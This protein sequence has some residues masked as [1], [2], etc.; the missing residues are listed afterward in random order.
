MILTIL[1]ANLVNLQRIHA[2]MNL[3]G[4]LVEHTRIHDTRLANALYLFWCLDQFT[5]RHQLTFVFPV[6]DGLVHFR[7]FLT[8]QTVPSLFLLKCVHFFLQVPFNTI[9]A[10]KLRKLFQI[11]LYL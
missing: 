5:S 2:R 6:H 9:R 8:R 11:V 10:A 7:R 1:T 4:H 3:L